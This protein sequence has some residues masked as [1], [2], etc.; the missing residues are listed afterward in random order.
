MKTYR[1]M[2]EFNISAKSPAEAKEQADKLA[3]WLNGKSPHHKAKTWRAKVIS[4]RNGWKDG[5]LKKGRQ[6]NR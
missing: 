5:V 3:A 4:D 1:M 6:S 2:M